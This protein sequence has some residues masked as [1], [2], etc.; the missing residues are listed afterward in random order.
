MLA[1]YMA[2]Q[3]ITFTTREGL[4]LLILALHP[5]L[6]GLQGIIHWTTIICTVT[7]LIFIEAIKVY[8]ASKLD[9]DNPNRSKHTSHEYSPQSIQPPLP[10]KYM[11]LAGVMLWQS[12]IGWM[13]KL[14]HRYWGFVDSM[15]LIASNTTHLVNRTHKQSITTTKSRLNRIFLSVMIAYTIP[16]TLASAALQN[17][18]SLQ[19]LAS[20]AQ[21]LLSPSNRHPTQINQSRQHTFNFDPDIPM[22]PLQE[23]IE[24]DPDIHSSSPSVCSPRRKSAS[25]QSL[26][27]PV[28]STR[29]GNNSSTVQ[30][31]P[32]PDSDDTSF[33]PSSSQPLCLVA[34]AVDVSDVLAL[35]NS[36]ITKD[37][38]NLCSF[39][40]TSVPTEFGTDNCATHHICSQI[41][42]F[43][44]MCKSTTI[45]VKGVAGSSL[46]EGI[47]TVQF[48]IT[49]EDG[50]QHTICLNN[51]IYLPS[52][53]KNLIST[54]QWSREKQDDCGVLSRQT[55]SIFMWEHDSLRKLI[56][57]EPGCAIP[58]MPVNEQNDAFLLFSDKHASKFIDQSTLLPLQSDDVDDAAVC[59]S[60]KDANTNKQFVDATFTKCATTSS[61]LVAGDIV[62]AT[63]NNLPTIAIIDKQYTIADGSHR[64]K[65]RP[66]NSSTTVTLTAND[67]MAIRPDP[68]DIPSSPNDVD[69]ETMTHCLTEAEMQQIW[70]SDSDNTVSEPSRQTLYWHHRLRCAPLRTLHRLSER[71][72]IPKCIA[73][74]K[75]MPLCASCAYAAA[76]RKGWRVKGQAPSSIRKPHHDTPGAGTS[77]DHIISHQPG[78]IPQ[79]TG[80][81]THERFWG[82]V[83]YVDHHSDYMYNHLITGTTS[84]A[85]LESKLAYE[86]VAASHGVN[87]KAYHAD[88]LRFNDSKFKG[89]C[90]NAGQQLS[91]C[92]VGAHHQN[93][94]V[95]SKI[96][97]LCYGGRTILLHA[98]RK[99]SDVIS[100][101]LWPYAVQAVVERHNRLALDAD[102]RSPLEKFT[103]LTDDKLPTNF[104]TWGCPV[105]VLDAANQSG[106][107]GTPKWEP[108]SHT[109][110]YL[111][112]SP[113]HAGSVS[114]VLNLKTG[115]VSPQFHVIYDDEF[116]TVPYLSSAEP[117]PNWI[118]LCQHAVEHCSNEQ[119]DLSYEWLHPTSPATSTLVP[120]GASS[121]PSPIADPPPPVPKGV[122]SSP[123]PPAAPIGTPSHPTPVLQVNESAGEDTYINTPF[124]NLDTLGLR[125]SPRIKALATN[126][127]KH[128]YGLMVLALSAFAAIPTTA[129]AYSTSCFQ[130]RVIGYNDFLETNFDGSA[131]QTS[132]LAQIY[133][134]SQS[135]NETY[136]LKEMVKQPDRDKF[137]EA[138]ELEVASMFKENIWLAVPKRV[139]TEHYR[140]E[141][142]SGLDVKRHQIMMIWSFKRKRHPDGS[143]SKHKARLCC[144]GGQQQWGVNYWDTYAPVVSWSS[145]RILMTM[146]KLHNL[147]TKS[148]DFVQAYPQAELKSTIFLRSPPGVELATESEEMVLKLIRNLYGLKDAG[149]TWYEHLT[150]GL[151]AMG[152]TP[153]ESDPCIFIRGTDIMVL[154]VDDCIIISQTKSDADKIYQDLE[155]R[156]YKLT[157][158]GTLEEYLGL[159]IKQYNDGSFRV[160]Q[161][162]LIDRIVDSIPGMND[163]RSAKSP[164]ISGAVLTKDEYGESR[165]EHWNYRSVIGMLNYLVNC[166]H[167]ELS[168]AVHQCARF[169]N[170]P[171]KCHEQAVKRILRYLIQT[172]R[173]RDQGIIF[174]PDKSKSVDCYVDASFAGEWNTAWSDEPSSVMSRTGYIILYANCPIIWG[175]KLQTEIALS[176][177]E[178]EYIAFSQALRD[179]IPLIELLRELS[180]SIPSDTSTPIIHCTVHEDNKGCIDLVETPKMRPRTKH[181]ALKYHHFRSFVKDKTVSVRYCETAL[182]IADI[183]TK[184]LGDAQ[185][186]VLRKMM[187]GW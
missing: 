56:D 11:V 180:V 176:T 72:L 6:P 10:R 168:F 156:K 175:S 143:L 92:G 161:P 37:P 184:P 20:T 60:D 116:T 133:L 55:Y 36:T 87:I 79:S 101:I 155:R 130:S 33:P 187:M 183:F 158:E 129:T 48:T 32:A 59:T 62:K 135:N 134:S 164:S 63:I 173:T 47:G 90:I 177:T 139:M 97:E 30:I 83:L 13:E 146:A 102:G 1:Y 111:G 84:Q 167:P 174:R 68:T 170:D 85:T 163:A 98:K 147:H 14:G 151:D 186:A 18:S 181:I 144:H 61:T 25:L 5:I 17:S 75:K 67:I 42:L 12:F 50:I 69:R 65:V 94:V 49:D 140:K 57:H 9:K 159:Q 166:S 4:H 86:R 179:V 96:K 118:H 117:P 112:H 149:R 124:V 82:S 81:M 169:C 16:S 123:S 44:S 70:S 95:E 31:P 39:A 77:C 29:E 26:L 23:C 131:N 165:L 15:H 119:E 104:H 38:K 100:T 171:K 162:M 125:R 172:T 115:M 89:S 53:A 178:S 71:G 107:I 24:F 109:G 58:L 145:I 120:K 103:G 110:I 54:S 108:R 34:D 136:T 2:H 142:A 157:D 7:S 150:D 52:A 122:K 121:P 182:Q 21:F 153:T 64:Y 35:S 141:R 106:A 66:L 114:L 113:C 105:Y 73:R 51:V 28:H 127:R 19:S 43:T 8:A 99:W 88:N 27:S 74:V 137:I 76:H 128:A 46:A 3:T 160:S 138:M 40:S 154:Y 22:P 185:F 91:Y 132:P 126:K 93:A 148:I 78:L 152:F 80:I 45:G 41:E